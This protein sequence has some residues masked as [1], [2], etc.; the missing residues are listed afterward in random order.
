M[1]GHRADFP[2]NE[3]AY[4]DSAGVA[5]YDDNVEHLGAGEHLD[6]TRCYLALESLIGPEQ[7]LLSRLAAS[8]ER[9]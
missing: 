8:V 4:D 1:G 2:R 5:V 6:S 3:V 9:A 7:Q